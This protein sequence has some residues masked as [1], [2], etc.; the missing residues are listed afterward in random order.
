M[1]PAV[2]V[3]ALK[4]LLAPSLVVLASVCSRRFGPLAGG[5][6]GGLPVVAGPILLVL[7]VTHGRHFG[8]DAARAS[9]L[10]LVSLTTFVL[11]YG[12]LCRRRS[13]K[14][15]LPLGWTAFL[16]MTGAL[17]GISVSTIASLGLA[18]SSFL[19]ALAVLP[20]PAPVHAAGASPPWDL[21]V[22]AVTAAT[23]VFALTAASS[24]LGSHLSGLLAP[25]PIITSVLAAFT[26]A[27]RGADETLVL[28]RGMLLGFFAFA[29]F[30]TSVAA[31]L[32]RMSTAGAFAIASAVALTALGMILAA[33]SR[34]TRS[35]KGATLDITR[36]R[37]QDRRKRS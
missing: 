8:S 4:L 36:R 33:R 23:M 11:V 2:D 35:P 5:V 18:V 28:L 12:L 6:V 24:A 14:L 27:Q 19:V 10:G 21:P 15:A 7:A 17:S 34:R 30:C 1:L 20:A 29:L 3:L 26:H 37:R 13:W 16:A 31:A 9:S 25:F 32:P 22:R